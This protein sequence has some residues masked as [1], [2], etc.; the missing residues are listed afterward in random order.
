MRL[1]A[2]ALALIV[3][4]AASGDDTPMK[5]LT[6][7]EAAKKVNEKVTV[8]VVVKSTGG[9]VNCYLNSEEDFKD[10]K[11]FAVFIPEAAM[12]KFKKAKIEDPKTFYKGK[13]VHVTGTVT[14]NRDKPQIKIEEPEHIKVIETKPI[15]KK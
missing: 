10:S 13:T 15:E 9:N 7:A 11:N 12:E 14:T 6:P 5:P 4:V 1:S 8:E 3:V 2:L